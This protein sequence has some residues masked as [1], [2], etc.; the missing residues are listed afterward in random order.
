MS[1]PQDIVADAI[2][3]APVAEAAVALIAKI[4]QMVQEAKDAKGQ[5]HDAILAR[6]KAA[7]DSLAS[8]ADAAHQALADEL[9][10]DK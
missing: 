2:N 1:T 10:K 6:L 9:A 7:E 3:L 4:I 5:Q 8:A